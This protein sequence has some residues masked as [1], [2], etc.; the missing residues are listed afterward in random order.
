[1]NTQEIKT[2]LKS[3]LSE[4]RYLHTLRVADTAKK[5]A[6]YHKV[7]AQL[8]ETAALLHDVAKEFSPAQLL[9]NIRTSDIIEP[10][11]FQRAKPIWHAFAGGNYCRQVLGVENEDVLNAITYHTTGRPQMSAL[12]KVVFLSDLT[13]E[14]RDFAG[15]QEIRQ[16]SFCNLDEAMFLALSQ[17]IVFLTQ[18]KAVVYPQTVCAYNY[19]LQERNQ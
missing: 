16:A 13:E 7:D 6:A 19:Y 4:K 10:A 17:T 18:K 12:E 9:Q 1:M 8:A 3:T 14:K 2:L 11:I 5:M 15:V